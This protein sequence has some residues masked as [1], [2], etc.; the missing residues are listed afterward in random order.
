MD[1]FAKQQWQCPPGSSRVNLI[2]FTFR[3]QPI[4]AWRGL[5]DGGG[6]GGGGGGGQGVGARRGGVFQGASKVW[7]GGGKGGRAEG[8]GGGVVFTG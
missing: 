3:L 6:G 8:M 5:Q 4:I 1:I 7:G 2:R